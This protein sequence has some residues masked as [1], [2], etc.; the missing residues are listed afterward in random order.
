MRTSKLNGRLTT[1]VAVIVGVAL[2]APSG[3]WAEGSS[4]IS[5][6]T[7]V[8]YGQLETGNTATGQDLSEQYCHYRSYWNVNVTAGDVLTVDWSGTPETELKLMPVGTTDFTQFETEPALSEELSPN[9]QAQATYTVPVSGTMP[10]YFRSCGAP[11][12]YSFTAMFQ[13][14]LVVGL[15]AHESIL[16]NSVINGTAAL[17]TGG[18]VPDGTSFTLTA[19]WSNGSATYTATS[20]GGGLSFTLALPEATQ[21]QSVTLA[22]SRAADSTYAAPATA[23][24]QSYVAKPTVAPAPVAPA[25]VKHHKRHQQH[26]RHHH[27]HHHHRRHHH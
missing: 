14:G 24:I 27:H 9:N 21:G 8:V 16:T 3:A 7:P 11:G 13:H 4:S 20:V 26:R 19:T 17:S 15:P 2:M 23:T 22:L 10:L 12:P 25:P 1:V 18:P 6:G 5:T